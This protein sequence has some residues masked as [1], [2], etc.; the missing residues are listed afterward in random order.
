MLSE[1]ELD[2]LVDR[3][4]RELNA[5]LHARVERQDCSLREAKDEADRQHQRALA[6][7]RK[8]WR[9]EQH[10]DDL[11]RVE[12]LRSD[13]RSIGAAGAGALVCAVALA[14][15]CSVAGVGT[16]SL[17][18]VLA[19][20]AANACGYALILSL[21]TMGYARCQYR[22][23]QRRAELRREAD[24]SEVAKGERDGGRQHGN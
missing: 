11:M 3:K 10:D 17:L 24:L 15:A 1:S 5:R 22:E 14:I 8:A 21:L 13:A 23:A 6:Q 18:G 20:I 7:H 19:S 9:Q 12:S 16:S 2:T 4:A